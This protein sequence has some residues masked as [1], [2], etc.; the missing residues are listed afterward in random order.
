MSLSELT[1][2]AG[3]N[4]QALNRNVIGAAQDL[5]FCINSFGDVKS[6]ILPSYLPLVSLII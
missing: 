2:L 5:R 1:R 6:S 3:S 4:E